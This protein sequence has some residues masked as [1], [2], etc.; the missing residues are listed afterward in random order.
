MLLQQQLLQQRLE[1]V[2]QALEQSR[3]EYSH[4]CGYLKNLI[5]NSQRALNGAENKPLIEG[6]SDVESNNFIDFDLNS[7]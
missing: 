2:Q 4:L 1:G 5:E 7:I 3:N 6:S